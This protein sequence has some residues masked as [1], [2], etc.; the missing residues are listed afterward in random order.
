MT[1]CIFCRIASKEIPADVVYEDER[2]LA[3]RDLNPQAPT[4]VLIIPKVHID[5]LD[6][7]KAEQVELL[8][9]LQMV[10]R[11]L[12][13]ELDLSEEGYRVVNNCGEAGGQTVQ[14]LHY[15]LLGGRHMQWPPG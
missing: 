7:T 1:D 11:D 13:R 9:Y 5:S 6:A 3:F 14:H 4:H 12:A 8:G 10:A 15:H 2:A